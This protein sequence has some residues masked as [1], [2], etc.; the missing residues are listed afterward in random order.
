MKRHDKQVVAITG[1][2]GNL[3]NIL[4]LNMAD[5]EVFLH[6]LW[7]NKPINPSLTE[8]P[9]VTAF[10][11]DLARRET[12][13][14]AL[15]DVD[16]VV[17]FAGVLFRGNP[18]KFLPQT[19][20]GYFANLLDAAVTA[21]VKRIVLISFPHVEG[22]TTP[23]HPATG[24][25]DGNPVSVHAST[26]LEEEKL[27][28]SRTGIEKVILRCGMVYGRGILMIDAARWFSRYGLLG[29]WRKPN[30]IHLIS[31]DDFVAVT[32][33]AV[34][35]PAAGGVYHIGDDG[36]QTLTEFLD[37]ATRHWGT[38]RPWRMPVWLIR[39]AAWLFERVSLMTGCRAPLTQDFITIGRVSYYGDTSRMKKDLLPKLKYPTFRD[40]LDTL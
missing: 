12:L 26:R 23:E 36:V 22:E 11:V 18:E 37:A 29:I 35:N 14:E 30:F 6:L 5:D 17:H 28:M 24:R 4:A 13:V 20:V 32:K 2:A 31:T 40:G 1:A 27:L 33:A 38:F 34:I 39:T 10:R 16:T 7:H 19:N 25:F 3:G 9:N 8:R 15:D 21:G